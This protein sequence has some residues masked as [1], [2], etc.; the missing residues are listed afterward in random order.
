MRAWHRSHSRKERGTRRCQW[1]RK[2]EKGKKKNQNE[3]EHRVLL[4]L[5]WL[6]RR[7][8]HMWPTVEDAGGSVSVDEGRSRHPRQLIDDIKYLQYVLLCVKPRY[9]RGAPL[10]SET[11]VRLSNGITERLS[12][13]LNILLLI[14]NSLLAYWA[15]G[16]PPKNAIIRNRLCNI[17]SQ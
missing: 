16:T 11:A 5:M 10:C 1:Y 2:E 14:V 8:A 15:Q 3:N 12:S 9:S 17:H 7:F 6:R 4:H 13:L